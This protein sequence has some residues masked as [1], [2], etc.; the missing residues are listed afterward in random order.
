MKKYIV[1][2]VLGLFS[3]TLSAQSFKVIVNNSN[4]IVSLTTED[5]SDYF[6]KK[7]VKLPNGQPVNPVDL[8]GNSS[9]RHD[10]SEAVHGKSTQ[11]IKSYWQQYVFSG[12]GTPPVE[13]AN[14]QEVIDYVKNNP[15]AIGY[16]SAGTEAVGVKSIS[17]T[18]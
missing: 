5:V 12:K 10:F 7:N 4:N 9:I 6:L 18:N 1:I 16:I 15:G 8:R 14:D 11:A 2:I 17:I 13:K 3:A